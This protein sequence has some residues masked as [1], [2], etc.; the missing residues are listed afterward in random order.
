MVLSEQLQKILVCP[1]CRGKLEPRG[2]KSETTALDCARCKLRYPV[3]D[4]IPV[5]LIDDAEKISG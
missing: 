5:M 1:K 4:G 3:R 2:D